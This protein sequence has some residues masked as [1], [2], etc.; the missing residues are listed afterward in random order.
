MRLAGQGG[1]GRPLQY[2][3]RPSALLTWP[4]LYPIKW[5]L[6]SIHLFLKNF[7]GTIIFSVQF[8]FHLHVISRRGVLQRFLLRG[9]FPCHSA[10]EGKLILFF[11]GGNIS[12]CGVLLD[13][14]HTCVRAV[15]FVRQPQTTT[16]ICQK[17]TNAFKSRR[18]QDRIPSGLEG[19]VCAK[20]HFNNFNSVQ[21][22]RFFVWK[23]CM[24]LTPCV[25]R[26]REE[27][28]DIKCMRRWNCTCRFVHYFQYIVQIIQAMFCENTQAPKNLLP[29]TKDISGQNS[30]KQ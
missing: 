23:A 25:S 5:H 21:L 10:V 2:L 7:S 30:T 20:P 27:I 26:W 24:T 16:S 4:V 29:K 18:H 28:M 14:S 9:W 12:T 6:F 11:V 1:G 13:S 8:L 15:Q 17:M 19:S 3:H 22:I